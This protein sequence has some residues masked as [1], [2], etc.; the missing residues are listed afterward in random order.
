[1][2]FKDVPSAWGYNFLFLE[3]GGERILAYAD[4]PDPTWIGGLWDDDDFDSV[5]DSILHTCAVEPA[6][7]AGLS[8]RH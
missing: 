5:V 8:A 6:A 1:M 7:P 3:A 4:P 2:H